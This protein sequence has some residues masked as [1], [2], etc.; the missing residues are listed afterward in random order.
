MRALMI[1]VE[2]RKHDNFVGGRQKVNGVREAAQNGAPDFAANAGKVLRIS[3]N[4][5]R[6]SSTSA[7]SSSPNPKCLPIFLQPPAARLENLPLPPEAEG[8]GMFRILA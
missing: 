8:R 4:S 6:Q 3:G 5:Q 7:L 2:Y 1:G